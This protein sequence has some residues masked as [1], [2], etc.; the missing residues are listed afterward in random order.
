M[1]DSLLFAV[2]FEKGLRLFSVSEP[3]APVELSSYDQL[4]APT[5]IS[6]SMPYVYVGDHSGLHVINASD[7]SS[8]REVGFIPLEPL[9]L[10]ASD[11][12]LYVKQAIWGAGTCS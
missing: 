2:D 8:L 12:Y 6:V 4:D 9:G 10:L 3:G 7:P 11:K 1:L 5:C